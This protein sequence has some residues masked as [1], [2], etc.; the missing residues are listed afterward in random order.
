[1]TRTFF[2]AAAV[3]TALLSTGASGTIL[4][5]DIDTA[6]PT[7]NLAMDQAY[8]DHVTAVT[9]GNASYGVGT[10][11]FTPDVTVSYAPATANLTRWS[12]GFG[13]LANVY[14]NEDDGDTLVA[15]TLAAEA[16]SGVNVALYGFD[17][18][19][20]YHQDYIIPD[21]K[22]V[23]GDG[24]VLFDMPD[25]LVQG[26]D[27]GTAHSA[28]TFENPLVG[29]NLSVLADLTGLGGN[30]DNIGFDNVRFGEGADAPIT[31]AVPEP[32]TWAMMISG[33]GL[34]GAVARRNG[35]RGRMAII[36]A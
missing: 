23:D 29:S 24:N 12:D 7:D 8:G 36:Q 25:F 18:G 21:L 15:F 20:Y 10:E 22:I 14:E 27:D 26:S 9:Q 1:M 16:G 33:F 13:D 19:G 30:S 2:M 35:R 4:T 34:V 28:V 11:G 5:F 32:A 6:R 17:M 3:A 31:P